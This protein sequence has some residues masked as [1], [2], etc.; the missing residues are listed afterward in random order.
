MWRLCITKCRE[1]DEEILWV[2]A[3]VRQ[4]ELISPGLFSVY[5]DGVV[6]E[7]IASDGGRACHKEQFS[8][9]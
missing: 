8:L 4:G 1:M 7:A 6:R 3:G 5:M 2:V 9:L